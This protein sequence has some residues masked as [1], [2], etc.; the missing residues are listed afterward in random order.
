MSTFG[1]RP[2]A[3]NEGQYRNLDETILR[4]YGELKDMLLDD[5]PIKKKMQEWPTFHDFIVR[6]IIRYSKERKGFEKL[7][8]IHISI[9]RGMNTADRVLSN[10]Q[11]IYNLPIATMCDRLDFIEHY[12]QASKSENDIT[13]YL[14]QFQSEL[15]N[16]TIKVL[17]ELIA[18]QPELNIIGK[19]KR[20]QELLNPPP[21]RPSYFDDDDRC[22]RFGW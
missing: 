10:L 2:G 14:Y 18:N 4:L 19:R 16:Q 8:P 12:I 9:M 21:K 1:P 13:R 17:N 22:G 3:Q 11:Q 15:Q 5:D 6:N 7:R 20:E